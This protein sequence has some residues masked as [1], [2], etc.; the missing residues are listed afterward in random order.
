MHPA[1]SLNQCPCCMQYCSEWHHLLNKINQSMDN[2]TVQTLK[3]C[4]GDG[5][6]HVTGRCGGAGSSHRTRG[7]FEG[8]W[9]HAN[10]E[11]LNHTLCRTTAP[12][13]RLVAQ[14]CC[15]M[16][17]TP[18]CLKPAVAAFTCQH[19]ALNQHPSLDWGSHHM[20]DASQP[21]A[22][23]SHACILHRHACI[24]GSDCIP[25]SQLNHNH[26]HPKCMQVD[27]ALHELRSC[28]SLSRVQLLVDVGDDAT[29]PHGR[30]PGSMGASERWLLLLPIHCILS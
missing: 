25:T 5:A 10:V 22:A 15:C 23:Q 13:P 11:M 28:P 19:A 8:Q 4:C 24:P 29:E 18:A 7:P 27:R 3:T 30:P 26:M 20:H 14:L 1:P 16:S 2:I 17:Y 9:R 21:H 12:A 6:R